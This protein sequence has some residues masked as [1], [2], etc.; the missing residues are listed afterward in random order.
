MGQR[1]ECGRQTR[2]RVEK[3]VRPN[4]V[5]NFPRSAWFVLLLAGIS[6]IAATYGGI[7]SRY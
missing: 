5:E 7:S 3:K 1:N 4:I 2:L 6:L